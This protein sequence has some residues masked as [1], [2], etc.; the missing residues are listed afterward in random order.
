LLRFLGN[1][2]NNRLVFQ[3]EGPYDLAVNEAGPIH[4]WQRGEAPDQE[5]TLWTKAW[6]QD[7]GIITST[8]QLVAR[9]IENHAAM[10]R[11]VR[12]G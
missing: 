5:G 12:R 10:L 6:K 8:L 1:V 9:L 4:H 3:K 11:A 7:M 2:V